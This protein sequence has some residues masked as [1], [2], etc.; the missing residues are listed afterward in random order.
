M[1]RVQPFGADFVE[2]PSEKSSAEVNSP[3]LMS[4]SE[5]QAKDFMN[6]YIGE[7]VK[8]DFERGANYPE[9]FRDTL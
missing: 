4:T 2:F 5:N 3:L 1:S 9:F 8:K 7:V 6:R